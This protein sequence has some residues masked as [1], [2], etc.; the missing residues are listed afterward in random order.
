VFTP[1]LGLDPK[2]LPDV[3]QAWR[4][5]REAQ[6]GL[7]LEAARQGR[8]YNAFSKWVY[9]QFQAQAE[10]MERLVT[11]ARMHVE[12]DT[13]GVAGWRKPLVGAL[14][15]LTEKYRKLPVPSTL[16]G[17]TRGKAMDGGNLLRSYEK[18]YQRGR[19]FLHG[20]SYPV[21][22]PSPDQ[23]MELQYEFLDVDRAD[24][25]LMKQR[26]PGQFARVV[27]ARRSDLSPHTIHK[28]LIVARKTAGRARPKSRIRGSA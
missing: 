28:H 10:G 22:R 18:L 26:K 13:G 24:L 21:G 17:R 19:V 9:K 25:P 14:D 12:R 15:C 16:R 20:H 1:N 11:A 7:F 2:R 23:S 8:D 6:N 3:Q 27:V 5:L 4:A